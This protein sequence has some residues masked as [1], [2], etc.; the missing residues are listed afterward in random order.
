[1]ILLRLISWPYARKH[2]LRCLLTTAGIVLGVGVFVGMR[3]ANKSVLAAFN[4]TIDRI[5]GAAQLQI[6]AGDAGFDEDVLDKVREL[7]EVRAAAPVIEATV[8]TDKNNL[9]ILGVD[10]LGD[11]NIRNYDLEG[12][13]DAI[14]DPLIFLA[15]PDSLMVT[16]K[17]ADERGLAVNSKLADAHH[18]RRPGV[19]RARDHEAGRPGERVRRRSGDHGHLRGAEDVRA[20]AQVRPD[21]YR[22][23]RG[24]ATR[25]RDREIAGAARLGISG[26]TA[27]LAR[28]AV[29][30]DVAHVRAGVQHHQRVRAVHRDVHHLQ[31]LRD[32][33]DGAAGGDR[34]PA[35]AGSHTRPDPD[36]VSGGKRA[37]GAGGNV[38]GSAV[39]H[40]DGAR[41]VGVH[42]RHAHGDLRRRAEPRRS[43]A[44]SM[45]NWHGGG[46]GLSHEP[47]GGGDPGAQRGARGS[48][49]GAA[50]GRISVAG[51][52]RES[53]AAPVGDR[54]RSGFGSG[55]RL[56]PFRDHDVRGLRAGDSGGGA[57]LAG[58]VFLAVA[59]LASPVSGTET[60]GRRAGGGQPDSSAAA[61]LGNDCG[62]DA[63]ARAGDFAGWTCAVE[64][65]FAGGVDAHRAESGFLRDHG[66]NVVFAELRVSPRRW[67]TACARSR[68]S[69]KCSRCAACA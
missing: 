3:T 32:R 49:E 66:R 45:A 28:A 5:A 54:V 18:A 60:G 21:R 22:T 51:R 67:R 31:H 46:D 39:R 64:L 43:H 65:R 35:R 24:N 4:Q 33:G 63:V 13:D 34:N 47:G 52:R 20:R 48:G 40:R 8:A 26:G 58:A 29:R 11:R 61:D 69:P 44:R 16:K 56:Q 41:D 53:R 27:Q 12:S 50:E 6:T 23:P 17:F 19:H 36:A 30:I 42:R 1:M 55:V 59:S 57:A 38:R 7:P 2:L 62:A 25:R 10:M 37:G 14:D 15:Q 68:A 9:L